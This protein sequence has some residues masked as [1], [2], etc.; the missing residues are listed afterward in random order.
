LRVPAGDVV[1]RP[2]VGQDG[3]ARLQQSSRDRV[4]DADPA[5][6]SGDYCNSTV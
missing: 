2:G 5:T 3:G 6:D 4:A 1:R